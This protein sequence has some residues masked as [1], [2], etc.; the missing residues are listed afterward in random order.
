MVGATDSINTQKSKYSNNSHIPSLVPS[1]ICGDLDSAKEEIKEYYRQRG[2]KII[3]MDD[4]DTND[5]E[6]SI[7]I[8]K[9]DSSPRTIV[10]TGL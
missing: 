9:Q 8:L 1:V 7:S 3:K 6:K 4:Q 2:T 5:L 10:V